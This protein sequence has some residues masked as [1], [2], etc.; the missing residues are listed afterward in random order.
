MSHDYRKQAYDWAGDGNEKLV[1]A[2]AARLHYNESL[3][4]HN[5]GVEKKQYGACEY[6]WLRAGK[7]VR[8]LVDIGAIGSKTERAAAAELERAS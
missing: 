7:A 1:D 5:L 2:V 4:M 6:C 8:A 3:H